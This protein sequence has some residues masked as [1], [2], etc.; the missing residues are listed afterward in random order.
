MGGRNVEACLPSTLMVR[1]NLRSIWI[2][3]WHT[4]ELELELERVMS[5]GGI[6][7]IS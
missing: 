4:L 3:N 6:W 7:L 2:S 1:F 5:I